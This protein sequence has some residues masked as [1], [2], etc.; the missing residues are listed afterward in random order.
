M[1]IILQ[2]DHGQLW[3]DQHAAQMKILNAYYLPKGSEV[4]YPSISPV[5]TFR[6]VFNEYLGGNFPL[7]ED[8]SY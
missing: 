2:G 3:P 6:V 4:L 5:N 1:A 7:L 8:V